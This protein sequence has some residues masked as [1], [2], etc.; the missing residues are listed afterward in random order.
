[1][2][3]F[4]T[5]GIRD[6]CD[7]PLLAPEFVHRLGRAIGQ[8]LQRTPHPA[9]R[10]AIIGRDTRSTGKDIFQALARGLHHEGIR[11]FDAGICPTPAVASS[12]ISL[13]LDL[14]IVIT[15]S[16]NPARDNGIKLFGADGAKL[17]E[18]SELEIEALVDR[19]DSTSPPFG[20]NPPVQFHEA[21]RHYIEGYTGIIPENA[22]MG[23]RLV[24]DSANGSTS[25]SSGECLAGFGAQVIPLANTPNGS[26]IN[27]GVGSEHPEIVAAATRQ[28]QADLGISHD[29]DGDRVILCDG[30]GNILDGD[31]ILALLGDGW[32]RSNALPGQTLVATVMS[33]LGLDA[34]L[35]PAGVHVHRVGIGDRQVYYAMKASGAILGGESSGHFISLNHL[36]T[37]DG[38]LAAL[39]VLREMLDQGK[40]LAD[41][42]ALYRPFP[43]IKKNLPVVEKTDL[44]AIPALQAR[45]DSIK[46]GLGDRGR[47]LLRY[48]GTEPKIRL[49]AEAPDNTLAAATLGELEDAVRAFLPVAD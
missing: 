9:S 33:N 17:P 39:L 29:G 1:M 11:I 44:S 19:L 16:H 7:G 20:T 8:W 4:G 43:Q 38:L 34:C 21:R 49:L 48:S 14:G 22:L 40:S 37:G 6:R 42:T 5:D 35:S 3:Y 24:L 32:A 28:H 26:N 41:L 27:H 45:L 13:G 15:A 31:A 10:H 23:M 46:A 2:K 36:P 12:V 18:A 25:H 30:T 47:I